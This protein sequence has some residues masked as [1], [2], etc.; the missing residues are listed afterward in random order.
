VGEIVKVTSAVQVMESALAEMVETP[1]VMAE[2]RTTEAVPS[3]SDVRLGWDSVPRM[4]VK[5]TV[6]PLRG[7]A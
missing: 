4:V 2:V 6:T 3:A 5:V 7:L 1:G